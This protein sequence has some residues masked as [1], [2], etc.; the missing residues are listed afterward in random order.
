MNKQ[1]SIEYVVGFLMGFFFGFFLNFVYYFYNFISK[2]LGWAHLNVTWWMLIPI[3]LVCGLVMS[4][5]I[6]DMHLED[7]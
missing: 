1:R 3:P 5:T 6:A 7:Y 4:K 2:W